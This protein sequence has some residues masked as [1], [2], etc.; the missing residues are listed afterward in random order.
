[1]HAIE[2][3]QSQRHSMQSGADFRAGSVDMAT[4]GEKQKFLLYGKNGWIGGMLIELIKAAGDEVVLGNARL[5]NREAVAAEIDSV[6]PTRVL[7]AAGVTGRPN[8]D[9]LSLIHI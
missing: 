3:T 5:E 7:N 1:M 9:W 4:N 2:Q 6:K 8:V